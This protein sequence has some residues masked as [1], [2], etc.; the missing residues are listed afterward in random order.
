MDPV[1]SVLTPDLIHD[2]VALPD[3]AEVA[4]NKARHENWLQSPEGM[5]A[6]LLPRFLPLVSCGG[7]RVYSRLY[8][9]YGPMAKRELR[10]EKGEAKRSG[11]W[12]IGFK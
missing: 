12:I 6:E 5:S 8:V 9:S 10:M 7:A 4:I 2:C 1:E 11:G 3:Q